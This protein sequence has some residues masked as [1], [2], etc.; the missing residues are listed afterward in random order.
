ML[1]EFHTNCCISGIAIETFFVEFFDIF[2]KLHNIDMD[3]DTMQFNSIFV[4]HKK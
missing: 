1:K 3:M 4:D 2:N